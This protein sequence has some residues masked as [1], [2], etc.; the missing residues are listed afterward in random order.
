M[1]LYSWIMNILITGAGSGIGKAV[2]EY[3]AQLSHEVY[4][5]DIHPAQ[6]KGIRFFAGDITDE[7]SLIKIKNILQAEK[8]HFDL[9]MN[10]AG[11]HF[12]DNFL[13]VN[14]ERLHKIFDVN[15]LGCIRVNRIFFSL[16]NKR[17][18]IMITTSEV[19]PLDALP[20]NGIYSVTKTALDAYAQAL[21]HEAG[22]LGVKVITVRPGAVDTPLS[23]GSIPSM[24]QMVDKSGY[25]SGQAARFEQLMRKFTGKMMRPELFAARIYKISQKKNPRSVYTIHANIWLKLLSLL[26]AGMQVLIVRKLVNKA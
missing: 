3:C 19:A 18:R 5:I 21:R 13:E 14:E 12:I 26:P 10:F 22:F 11:I 4:A 16:L 1:H 2:A 23:S 17:A 7:G 8:I 20:F 9:I 24:Q 6:A 15:V 25:F